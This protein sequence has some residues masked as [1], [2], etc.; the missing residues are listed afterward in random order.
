MAEAEGDIPRFHDTELNPKER[1]YA[2]NAI[3]AGVHS[4]E[5]LHVIILTRCNH[6]ALENLVGAMENPEF[7]VYPLYPNDIQKLYTII[8]MELRKLAM[9][10]IGARPEN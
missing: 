6:Y 5:V 9:L 7:K 1:D 10:V 2:I 8:K 3:R 4:T